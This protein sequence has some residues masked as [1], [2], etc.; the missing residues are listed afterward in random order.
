MK[1]IIYCVLSI[2][3][4]L[5]IL[6]IPTT[7]ISANT[8]D[9]TTKNLRGTWYEYEGDYFGPKT[10]VKLVITKHSFSRTEVN[11]K[12]KK[13]HKAFKLTPSQKGYKKLWVTTSKTNIGK[14]SYT[15]TY[16]NHKWRSHADGTGAFWTEK[17]NIHGKK[18]QFL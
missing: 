7:Y 10:W 5:S 2:F 3:T 17:R 11:Q 18:E 9:T 13:L 6:I 4:A 8:H 14:K 1:K 15:S 16:F 12:G